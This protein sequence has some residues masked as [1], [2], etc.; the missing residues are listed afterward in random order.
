LTA[1]EESLGQPYF[2]SIFYYCFGR[3]K[4]SAGSTRSTMVYDWTGQRARRAKAV[5]FVTIALFFI[6]IVGLPALFMR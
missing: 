5:R 6:L 4:S 2:G 3:A 1:F